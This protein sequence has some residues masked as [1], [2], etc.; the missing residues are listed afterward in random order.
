M[1]VA[2]K[3]RLTLPVGLVGLQSMEWTPFGE[4][5]AM[6]VVALVPTLIFFLTLRERLIKGMAM[7]G[8]KG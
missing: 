8:V 1:I 6:A 2:S 7:V 5:F 3:D 4:I